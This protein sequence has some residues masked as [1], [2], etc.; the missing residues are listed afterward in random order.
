MKKYLIITGGN[1]GIGEG[2]VAEYKRNGYHIISLARTINEGDQYDGVTQ[3]L[4]DLSKIDSLETSFVDIIKGIDKDLVSR[5][6][7]INNAGMVGKIGPL[8]TNAVEQIQRTIQL[9]TVAPVVLTS[10]FLKETQNWQCAKKIINVSSGA[11]AKPYFG[12]S[13]YCASKAALD[14]MTRVV[15]VEQDRVE[16]GAKIIAIYPGV[17]DTNMQAEIRKSS[18]ENFVDLQRFLDLKA[19][20]S[21][22][23]IETIGK[24]IFAIDLAENY[25]NGAILNVADY[26]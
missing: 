13:V 20:G 26:R 17:V 14:M 8:E 2:I 15:A 16:N 19:S 11:A 25:Q 22:V 7:L 6:I 5:I 23:T 10:L 3:I 21:L 1:K 24:E 18:A 12:W 9:N 4:I